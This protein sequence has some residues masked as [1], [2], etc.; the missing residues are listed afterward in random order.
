SS[1]SVTRFAHLQAD[2]FGDEVHFFRNEEDASSFGDYAAIVDF[3]AVIDDFSAGVDHV[4]S[5]IDEFS[6]D[7]AVFNDFVVDDFDCVGFFA[8]RHSPCVAV[9]SCFE[10]SV[11]GSDRRDDDVDFLTFDESGDCLLAAL[12]DFGFDFWTET[13][14]TTV[15]G[16]DLNFSENV[17]RVDVLAVFDDDM[18]A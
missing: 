5:V 6:D 15:F 13:H 18:S 17:V 10:L 3:D 1:D 9:L 7:L 4:G 8:L 16:V 2:V 14:F 11:A 12:N